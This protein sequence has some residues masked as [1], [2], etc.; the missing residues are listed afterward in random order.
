V[1]ADLERLFWSSKPPGT[2]PHDDFWDLVSKHVDVYRGHPVSTKVTSL[3]LDNGKEVPTDILLAGTGWDSTIPFLS[4]QQKCQLGLPHD[5]EKDTPEETQDWQTLTILARPRTNTDLTP[6][7]LYQGVAPL[8]DSSIVFLGKVRLPNGFFGA[9]AQAIWTTAYWDGHVNIPPEEEVRRK[10]AYMNAF[11]RRRYPLSRGDGLN[12]HRDLIWYIDTLLSDVGL[13][14][15]R[16]GWWVDLD[17]PFLLNDLRDC[18][19]EYLAKYNSAA[20]E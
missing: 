15:H 7:R 20:V 2:M 1:D 14:S 5:P 17:E 3:I 4:L 18:R 11:S 9:E 6:A 19:D 8:G 16:K 12:F 13:T 10:V